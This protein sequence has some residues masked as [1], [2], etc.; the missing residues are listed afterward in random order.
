MAGEG[1]GGARGPAREASAIRGG[2]GRTGDG[3]GLVAAGG[4][5]WTPRT[6][7]PPMVGAGCGASIYRER[8]RKR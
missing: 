1:G 5:L 6:Q 7:F 2:R 3:G 8:R 4:R